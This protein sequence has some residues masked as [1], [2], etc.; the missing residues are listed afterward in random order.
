MALD[1]NY[2]VLLDGYAFVC[3]SSMV[4]SPG[5]I[6]SQTTLIAG[7]TF[8]VTFHLAYPHRVSVAC[9][10]SKLSVSYLF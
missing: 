1:R 4:F 2:R 3:Y 8:A 9:L 6:S 5:S 10:T 7:S